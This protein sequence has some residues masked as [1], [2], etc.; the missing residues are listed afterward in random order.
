MA[1]EVALRSQARLE[2]LI[3]YSTGA[4][5]R[6]S[7]ALL[8]NLETNYHVHNRESARYSF[9]PGV[10][11]DILD[12]YLS[13]PRHPATVQILNDF[14]A[15]DR[16]DRMN[17]IASLDGP[18]LVIGDDSD[19]LT[20]AKYQAYL[21]EKIPGSKRV[22]LP[23]AGHMG[24]LEKPREFSAALREFIRSVGGGGTQ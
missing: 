15:A 20:P 19:N 14:R 17:D 22:I 1:I 13:L 16:F 4:R 2:G 5:L 23:G 7:P 18:V 6:V 8:Q 24:H 3:L 12:R 10:T 9:G 21:A 11:D